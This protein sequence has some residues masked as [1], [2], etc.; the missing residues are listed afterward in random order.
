MTL[1]PG[2]AA[3][4]HDLGD[5]F[6]EAIDCWGVRIGR[7]CFGHVGCGVDMHIVGAIG[8]RWFSSSCGV[9]MGCGDGQREEA[10]EDWGDEKPSEA[11]DGILAAQASMP[12]RSPPVEG[13]AFTTSWIVW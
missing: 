1:A 8:R 11:L 10:R 6:I 4:V 9:R 13:A 7:D 3:S 5:M 12:A 2:V